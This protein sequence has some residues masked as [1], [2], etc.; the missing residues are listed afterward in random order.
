MRFATWMA[1]SSVKLHLRK[2]MMDAG[3]LP[4]AP[5][6]SLVDSAESARPS[7]VTYLNPHD[8]ICFGCN[9]KVER[10][11][12][13]HC[14]GT[15]PDTSRPRKCVEVAPRQR[16]FAASATSRASLVEH[17]ADE[18]GKCA[19]S[20]TREGACA[21]LCK[22]CKA[23]LPE[24]VGCTSISISPPGTVGTGV[25]RFFGGRF[26]ASAALC[27]T[28]AITLRRLVLSCYVCTEPSRRSASSSGCW[29]MSRSVPGQP[30]FVGSSDVACATPFAAVSFCQTVVRVPSGAALD[31]ELS[32][33]RPYRIRLGAVLAVQPPNF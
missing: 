29:F 24:S 4:K 23:S 6:R 7:K 5:Q 30:R 31:G 33:P 13:T 16:A 12:S 22:R 28:R 21:A 19:A 3:H 25:L 2:A 14:D 26:A 15:T 17:G 10:T 18:G 11:A 27:R 1:Q 20:V 9:D 8:T 32:R